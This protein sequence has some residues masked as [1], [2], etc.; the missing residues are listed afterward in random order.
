MLSVRSN[1]LP[2]QFYV[3]LT[4]GNYRKSAKLAP[5]EISQNKNCLL[6]ISQA[7]FTVICFSKVS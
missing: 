6:K 7:T 3:N 5:Y 2:Q 4:R 1:F